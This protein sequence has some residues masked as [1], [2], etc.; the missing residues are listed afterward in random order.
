ME[1]PKT[2]HKKGLWSPEEDQKLRNYVLK[3]GHACWTS[4]PLSAGL[5]RNGKSCR[6][7]WINYLRPGLKRGTFSPQEE[8][9]ILNLH[10]LLGNKW[11]QI[12]QHLTGRTDNEIKNYWHS[13]LKKKLEKQ[14]CSSTTS[15]NSYQ[16]PSAEDIGQCVREPTNS[17]PK[18]LFAEWLSQ[19]NVQ[20]ENTGMASDFRNS[21]GQNSI[22]QDSLMYSSC[23]S[24]GSDIFSSDFKIDHDY[25]DQSQEII[26]VGFQYS[27]DDFFSHFNM[28]NY[29]TN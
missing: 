10:R 29:N 28:N 24:S 8:E 17:L 4:V 3:H 14:A 22:Y 2:K 12:A 5:E 19:D 6:L 9:I 7:R 18:P 21:M 25:Q 26:N 11:S 20:S 27:E 16:N 23:Y 15:T 1:L 13:Y